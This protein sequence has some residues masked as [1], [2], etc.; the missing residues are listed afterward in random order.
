MRLSLLALLLAL[1]ACSEERGGTPP[2]APGTP[3]RPDRDTWWNEATGA[4][5]PAE[6][7]L[8]PRELRQLL[9]EGR[10][11][12]FDADADWWGRRGAWAA[13]RILE[14]DPE[15]LE[16]NALAGR[17]TLQSIDGFPATWKRIVDTRAATPEMVEMLDEYGPFVEEGRPVFLSREEL[18]IERARLGQMAAY[19]D[20]LEGDPAYAAEQRALVYVKAS[21]HA[22]YPFLH[23]RVGPF[24]VFYA[25]RDLALDPEAKPAEE[26]QR[27]AGRREVYRKRLAD[28]TRVLPDLVEDLRTMF[29]DAFKAHALEAGELLPL[30]VFGDRDWYQDLAL[31]IRRDD[32]EAPYRMGFLQSATGWA[33]LV[34]PPDEAAMDLFRETAAYLGALQI[35]RHWARD[36]EDPTI[37]H[38]NRSEDYWFKE[39]LPAFLASRRVK[40][41][42]EGQAF[43]DALEMPRLDAVVGRRG[44]LDRFEPLRFPEEAGGQPAPLPDGGYT[45]LA[46]LLV[47]HLAKERRQELERFLRAQV[48]GTGKGFG[49]FEECFEVKGSAAWRELQRATYASIE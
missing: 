24:L 27:L 11:F 10:R 44:R 49:L 35:L 33:Y 43:R 14:L 6:R 9:A 39:G 46:W 37:N 32:E 1:G 2:T 30:W 23:E 13:E 47:R 38:W 16:A 19:L 4:G 3:S 18:D 40:V 17:E 12:G 5:S 15:D 41:P 45:D 34:E 20:R 22:D 7:V 48:E 42:I 29:P 26:E 31:R 36:A 28:W 21:V 25:A 8:A